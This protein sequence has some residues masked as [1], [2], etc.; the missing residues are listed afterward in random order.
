MENN[1]INIRNDEHYMDP[2]PYNA[3]NNMQPKEGEIW[4]YGENGGMCL[5][6]KAHGAYCNILR[7]LDSPKRE[8][9]DV[10]VYE[11]A[12]PMYTNPAFIQYL[13]NNNFVNFVKKLPYEDFQDVLLAVRDALGFGAVE[14]IEPLKAAYEAHIEDLEAEI[15]RKTDEA[16]NAFEYAENVEKER[17][18]D[19]VRYET[20]KNLYYE[21]V[22]RVLEKSV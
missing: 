16:Q 9:V 5:V 22:E 3:L 14:N 8:T 21:L 12:E 4:M 11:N 7:L 6:I 19:G 18:K 2:T 20:M 10:Y 13:M 15:A 17:M 1:K